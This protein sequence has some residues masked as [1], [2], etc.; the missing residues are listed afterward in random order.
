MLAAGATVLAVMV[1]A[2]ISGYLYHLRAF[3][4]AKKKRYFD[5]DVETEVIEKMILED[6]SV[7]ELKTW[8]SNSI[9]YNCSSDHKY[10]NEVPLDKVPR[11]KMLKWSCYYLYF[12]SMWQLTPEQ[13]THGEEIL[14]K[15][16]EKIDIQFPDIDDPDV[17]FLK[18]GNNKLECRY[19]PLA[20]YARLGVV[21]H[22]TYSNMRWN[23]FE[24]YNME[25]SGM[26]YFYYNN[27]NSD[28]QIM[29]IHGL[30]L[31][32]TPYLTYMKELKE[33]GSVIVPILPNLSN[34]EH[35]GMFEKIDEDAFF[36]SY[37]TIRSDFKKLLEYHN[38]DKINI[39]SHS[40]G[41]IVLG[42]LMRDDDLAQKI[43]KKVFVD[44]VCFVDRS[45][46]I[47]RYINEPGNSQD[48]VVN[49]VFNLLVYNDIYVRY[50][51]QRFLYGPEFWILDYDKLNNDKSLV[52]LSTKD[53]MVP[54]NSIYNRLRQHNVPCFMI[55][56]ANH[57]DIFLLDEFRG[58]WDMIKT[59]L[60][61]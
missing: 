6:M 15:I 46:K 45:F 49:S 57:A 38:I 40:F 59:F 33:L 37:E 39:V 9:S 1:G 44:P 30:G 52:V 18:F 28:R 24:A 35:H 20:L 7:E 17:Y 48:S 16:E 14:T 27:P 36:P 2:E 61:V 23:G 43:D 22:Y 4:F 50:I 60:I 12:K 58:V 47:F 34:M 13:I 21:K 10:Y 54:S 55:N 11:D 41:T 5:G 8:I 56:D 19:R 53:S 3:N 51:S 26:K 31:G 29:F 32:I 25:K 42:I